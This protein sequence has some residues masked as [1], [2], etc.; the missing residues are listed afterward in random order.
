ME[1]C[2]RMPRGSVFNSFK[3]LKVGES[4]KGILIWKS[5]QKKICLDPP[6][7]SANKISPFIFIHNDSFSRRLEKER[8]QR[9][10]AIITKYTERPT[11]FSYV[12]RPATNKKSNFFVSIFK[13]AAFPFKLPGTHVQLKSRVLKCFNKN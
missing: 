8:K 9:K 3:K 10:R 5:A 13:A 11:L 1:H 6:P 7:F 12:H 4:F 2:L